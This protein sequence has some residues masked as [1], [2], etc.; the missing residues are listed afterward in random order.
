MTLQE[1]DEL[2]CD[3]CGKMLPV[4]D[5]RRDG[6]R[7][8]RNYRATTCLGCEQ[9]PRVPAGILPEGWHLGDHV[10]ITDK[11]AG[12]TTTEVALYGGREGTVSGVSAIAG[13]RSILVTIYGGPCDGE[14][15]WFTAD[16]LTYIGGAR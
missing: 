5:F 2:E 12:W 14:A 11:R 9:E 13:P 10:R 6:R 4:V 16:E 1:H 8:T 15:R 3:T 7:T